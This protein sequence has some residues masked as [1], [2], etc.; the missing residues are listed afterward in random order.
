MTWLLDKINELSLPGR[1]RVAR[2][3]PTDTATGRYH[4]SGGRITG[5]G[6]FYAPTAT[7][8]YPRPKLWEGK[9]A[10]IVLHYTAVHASNRN[11]K[12]LDKLLRRAHDTLFDEEGALDDLRQD[13]D[14]VGYI[15]DAVSLSLQNAGKDRGAS[16]C[17]C[18]GSQPLPDGKLPVCQY[19]PNFEKFGTWHAGSPPTWKARQ[20]Y[21]K[22]PFYTYEGVMRWDGSDYVWPRVAVPDDSGD[23]VVISNVNA[24]TIGIEMM[25]VGKYT[26]TQK[27]RYPD[28]PAVWVASCCGNQRRAHSE[29]APAK[30]ECPIC[31]KLVKW[32]LYEEPSDLM[33]KTLR[34]IVS[35]LRK[36]YGDIPVWGHCDVSKTKPDPWPP[37]PNDL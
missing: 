37:F 6:V 15:P 32:V 25:N 21:G 28:L 24:Y 27:Y 30:E 18:V 23:S 26:A 22:T 31:G 1:L 17:I 16:W 33:V 14:D 7:K 19:S 2:P 10:A 9:P 35:A 11:L 4:V 34:D 29:K 13:L 12:S 3:F 8:V 5:D 36:E 20:K